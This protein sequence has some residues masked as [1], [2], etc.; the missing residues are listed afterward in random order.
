MCSVGEDATM[1]IIVMDANFEQLKPKQR[2]VAIKNLS[3]FLS[4]PH[5]RNSKYHILKK[6]DF[7]RNIEV[8]ELL[9]RISSGSGLEVR[10]YGLRRSAALTL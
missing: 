6:N 5:V 7:E 3:G 10:D 4:L 1:L 8:E 2:V 9:E